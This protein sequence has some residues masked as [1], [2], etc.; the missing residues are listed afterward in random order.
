M[1]GTVSSAGGFRTASAGGKPQI[2][3]PLQVLW[4]E[5]VE[6]LVVEDVNQVDEE[7]L[8][9]LIT[10]R[11]GC[12]IQIQADKKSKYAGQWYFGARHGDGHL[13][14]PDGSE[15]RGNLHFG[16]FNGYGQYI[17]PKTLAAGCSA[18]S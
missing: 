2:V 6:P 4:Q 16:Q 12:G 5:G 7:L 15:Y 17:W 18:D 1:G 11:H 10:V 3:D 13:V 8:P 9:K 14:N